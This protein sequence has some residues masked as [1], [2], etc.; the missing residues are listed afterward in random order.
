[1]SG[2]L[3][4]A[5]GPPPTTAQLEQW[6]SRRRNAAAAI[7]RGRTPVGTGP[8]HGPGH[9]HGEDQATG[10]RER[11]I[12]KQFQKKAD[13]AVSPE[14]IETLQAPLQ[15][16]DAAFAAALDKFF[17]DGSGGSASAKHGKVTWFANG[18]GQIH[19]NGAD[20]KQVAWGSLFRRGP[21]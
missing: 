17:K 4:S 16:T 1:M 21:Q 3:M 12:D 20:Q 11:K 19:W 15:K 10:G 18:T 8:D 5:K 14:Q 2:I 7:G 9:P 6:K 13:A